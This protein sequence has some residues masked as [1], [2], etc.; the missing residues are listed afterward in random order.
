MH[1]KIVWFYL[2]GAS[3]T[4][5]SEKQKT[6]V[7]RAERRAQELSLNESSVTTASYV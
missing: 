5:K 7:T 1:T 3:T 2:W 4:V 6:V